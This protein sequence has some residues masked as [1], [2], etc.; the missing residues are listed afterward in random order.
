MDRPIAFTRWTLTDLTLSLQRDLPHA[1]GDPAEARQRT[2]F[3]TLA[4]TK[5]FSANARRMCLDSPESSFTS[6]PICLGP[7]HP[8][9][10]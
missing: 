10:K 7:F 2:G 6:G 8:I 4:R 9:E 3:F 5:V 1:L